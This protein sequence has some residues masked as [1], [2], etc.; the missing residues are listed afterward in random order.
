MHLGIDRN[1]GSLATAGFDCF[2]KVPHSGNSRRDGKGSQHHDK[3]PYSRDRDRVGAC[4]N[5][6]F[7][8]KHRKRWNVG[9]KDLR[10][11][12]VEENPLLFEPF[13]NDSVFKFQP[14]QQFCHQPHQR[15]CNHVINQKGCNS[16][17]QRAVQITEICGNFLGVDVG[18]RK[19]VVQRI[20]IINNVLFFH[21][22]PALLY[23]LAFKIRMTASRSSGT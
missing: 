16:P 9:V 17:E 15:D 13:E 7:F 3:M 20:G 4:G 14:E 2:E 21:V 6:A 22:V 1:A 23:I 10:M 18:S 8:G 5:V 11:V 12:A 19:I